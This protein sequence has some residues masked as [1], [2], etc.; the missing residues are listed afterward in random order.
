MPRGKKPVFFSSGTYRVFRTLTVRSVF[1]CVLFIY[2]RDY[3]AFEIRHPLITCRI[4]DKQRFGKLRHTFSAKTLQ[5]ELF[6]AVSACIT[7]RSLLLL[8]S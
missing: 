6:C 4:R 1:L 8:A 7:T 2:E 5:H 3:R